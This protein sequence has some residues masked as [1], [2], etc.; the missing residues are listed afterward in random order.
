[1][2][3][4]FPDELPEHGAGEDE[5]TRHVGGLIRECSAPLGAPTSLAHM[6][7]PT[8][9][10]AADI[11]ALNAAANQNLLHP[12]LSPLATEAE[13]TLMRWL[14]PWFGQSWGFMCAGT[15]LG[16]LNAL[17]AAREAGCRRAV[18]S[19]E[20]HI[21]VPKAAHI[22]GLDTEVLPVDE[23]G[24]MVVSGDL[25]DAVLVATAGT[26][27]RGA[28]DPLH[29]AG[30]RWLHVD[31]AW[32]GPLRL[33]RYSDRLNGIEAAD[34][35]AVSAHKWFYQPKDSALVMFRDPDVKA[36]IAF[37]G[38]YLAVPNVGVQGSRSANGLALLATLMAWGRNGLA[39]RIEADMERAEGLA[40]WVEAQAELELSQRPACGVVNWRP[41][42]GA[43]AD[44]ARALDGVCSTTRIDG[45]LWMRNVAANP[46]ADLAQVTAAIAAAIDSPHPHP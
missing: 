6:D 25:S 33:T 4:L 35:V 42:S 31:A 13:D 38:A 36:S 15:T 7:P 23:A 10:V 8:P 1:M 32:G 19:T 11:V 24:R 43:S 44:L 3:T 18:F 45:E 27:G 40:D 29:R 16:N 14:T 20:A 2:S 22:L 39:A 21:S 17:W 37:G 26:T 28:I 9:A 5:A 34:S 12:S 41:R 46:H 30:A